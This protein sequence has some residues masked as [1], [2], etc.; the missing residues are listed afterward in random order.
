MEQLEKAL[1]R[2]AMK[3]S[4]QSMAPPTVET[5]T[6]IKS[7]LTEFDP[8]ENKPSPEIP[9]TTDMRVKDQTQG[10]K[11]YRLT[12]RTK[13]KSK[14]DILVEGFNILKSRLAMNEAIVDKFESVEINGREMKP[15]AFGDGVTGTSWVDPL[16]RQ[17]FNA[18]REGMMICWNLRDGYKYKYDLF[19]HKLTRVKV[20][21]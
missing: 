3:A 6:D 18:H 10:T 8:A 11:T 1:A 5:V 12:S 2:M 21:G 4:P 14:R 20:D 13:S 16:I 15:A 19:E 7:L 9:L 17:W